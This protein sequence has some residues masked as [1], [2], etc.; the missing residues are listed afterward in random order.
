MLKRDQEKQG[1]ATTSVFWAAIPFLFGVVFLVF[2]CFTIIP[3][4]HVGVPVLFGD[5][6]E[7]TYG[8]GIN[9]KNPLYKV[10]KLE[11][12]LQ[13]YTLSI[14][15]DEGEVKGK[16][17][18]INVLTKDGLRVQVDGTLHW[19]IDSVKAWWI[20]QEVGR[21]MEQLIAKVVRPAIRGATRD[22]AGKYSAT[23]LY[24]EKRNS[25]RVDVQ[26][27]LVERLGKYGVIFEDFV[28]RNIQL[29]ASVETAIELK[30]ATEQ[31]IAT[32]RNEVAIAEEEANRKIEEAR[33]IA[34]AQS[35]IQDT[36]TR[37]YLQWYYITTMHDLVDSPNNTI[38]IMPFDTELTPLLN[39]DK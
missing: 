20:Y 10:V 15:L 14:N 39:I 35:V 24:S 36:L 34:E 32:K 7:F 1:E 6:Q 27:D 9:A 29:P 17:D 3:S 8:Q 16:A 19:R 26:D 13:Q 31:Q 18:D 25:Y 33:G 37:E 38:V 12:R 23:D 11:T 28:L 2:S 30:Q 22:Q 21:D 5:V 4:G